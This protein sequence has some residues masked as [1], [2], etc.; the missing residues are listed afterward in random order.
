[1]HPVAFGTAVD[2]CG[3][4][5]HSGDL[6]HADRHGAVVIPA[7][8]ARK[9][10]AAATLCGRREQPILSAARSPGF[11]IEVLEAALAAADEIH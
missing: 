4:Q 9:L 3:M 8:A 6:I 1:V 10:A 2:I 5:V 7:N 11:S